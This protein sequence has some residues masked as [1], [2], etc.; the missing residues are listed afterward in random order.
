MDYYEEE[1][2]EMRKAII[3][4]DIK[5]INILLSGDHAEGMKRFFKDS[6]GK[7]TPDE[8]LKYQMLFS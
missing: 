5:R 7:D 2:K 8:W 1:K 4:K 3:E 6:T